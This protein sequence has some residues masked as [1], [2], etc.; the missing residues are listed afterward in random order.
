LNDFKQVC[1][2]RCPCLTKL[3]CVNTEAFKLVP[4][5]AWRRRRVVQR[6]RKA[7]GLGDLLLTPQ[8]PR[9]QLARNRGS[10]LGPLRT[11]ATMA[12]SAEFGDVYTT[13]SV[14]MNG[15]WQATWPSYA[16]LLS[17]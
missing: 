16:G 10:T 8:P 5:R 7:R 9:Q 11:Q 15:Q 3:V 1:Q 17:A 2:Q 13:R 12:Y 14:P 6:G 4:Q